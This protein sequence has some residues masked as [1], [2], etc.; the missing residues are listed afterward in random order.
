MAKSIAI[1]DDSLFDRELLKLEIGTLAIDIEF[2]EIRNNRELEEFYKTPFEIDLF[3]VD[4]LFN[5]S[6]N[7]N[8]IVNKLVELNPANQSKIIILSGLTTE[9]IEQSLTHDI[10]IVEK[11]IDSHNILKSIAEKLAP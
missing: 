5:D 9:M 1:I 8:A 6:N 7:G 10:K 3:I 4:W 11:S 2:K